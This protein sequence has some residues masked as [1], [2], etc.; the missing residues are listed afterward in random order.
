MHA[1]ASKQQPCPPRLQQRSG[2]LTHSLPRPSNSNSSNKKAQ[3][4]KAGLRR[5]RNAL[6]R[7]C[8]EVRLL[9]YVHT[10]R[11]VD[12]ATMH[13]AAPRAI[14]T[15]YCAHHAMHHVH[16]HHGT[17]AAWKW[18]DVNVGWFVGLDEPKYKWAIL[19]L[20][21]RKR[22]VSPCTMCACATHAAHAAVPAS[23]VAQQAQPVQA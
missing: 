22:E 2:K 8:G 4:R 21:R 23:R 7:R 10:T 16:C 20:E 3:A 17:P 6:Y 15:L 19:E 12:L 5:H 9:F 13:T 11:A 1:Q 18:F 14:G